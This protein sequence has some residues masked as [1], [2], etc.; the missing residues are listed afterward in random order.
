MFFFIFF[1][2]IFSLPNGFHFIFTKKEKKNT[3]DCG[4]W[5]LI[6]PYLQANYSA[7]CRFIDANG[8]PKTPAS[9]TKAFSTQGK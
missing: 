3:F 2:G 7:F 1:D 4:K 9:E 5:D 6:L 8:R